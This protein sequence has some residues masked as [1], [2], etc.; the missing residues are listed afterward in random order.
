MR[1]Q[2]STVFCAFRTISS[3]S[4]SIISISNGVFS[5][6]AAAATVPSTIPSGVEDSSRTPLNLRSVSAD[7]DKIKAIVEWSLPKNVSEARSFH[8]LAT[9]YR[10]FIRDFSSIMAPITNCL[11]KGEFRW[12]QSATEAFEL[13]KKKMTEAPVLRHPDFNKVFEVACDASGV[14]IGGV[15]SQ[16]N[17]PIAFFSEKLNESRRTKYSTYEKEFYALVRCLEHWRYYLLPKEFVLWSDHDALKFTNDQKKLKEKHARWVETLQ[18]FSFVLKHRS[19]VENVVADALSRIGLLLQKWSTTV[20]GFDRMRDAYISCVDFSEIY[21]EVSE[22]HRSTFPAYQVVDGYLFHGTRLCIPSTFLRDFLIW[23]LHDG[24]LAGHLGRDKTT[25][26]VADRFLWPSLR[27]DVARVVSQC[28]VC[29]LS[30][31][32]KQNTGLYTPLPIPHSPWKDLS[33]DFVLGIPRT[34]RGHDSILVVVDRFSKMAHFL[35]CKKTA[36][37][38]NI[39]CASKFNKLNLSA[40]LDT[41]ESVSTFISNGYILNFVCANN[42]DLCVLYV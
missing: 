15:L 4:P 42:E 33:M 13:V 38:S 28:R 25:I 14:G 20:V 36:D 26:L 24:G 21:S 3:S 7:P 1:R 11:R 30:K 12:S 9:F 18:D 8:G 10:R 22:G 19:G 29:Q 34:A 27:K 2:A 41:N 35:P 6:S 31:A 23:E 39:E 37:A 5:F 40:D 32:R 16:D 17:H